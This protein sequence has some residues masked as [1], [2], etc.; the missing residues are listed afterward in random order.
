[1]QLPVSDWVHLACDLKVR[2]LNFLVDFNIQLRLKTSALLEHLQR[3][4]LQSSARMIYFIFLLWPYR[5]SCF[6]SSLTFLFW[7][8]LSF[9]VMN[10]SVLGFW[11]TFLILWSGQLP[12][13]N[14]IFQKYTCCLLSYSCSCLCLLWPHVIVVHIWDGTEININIQPPILCWDSSILLS[15]YRNIKM[16]LRACLVRFSKNSICRI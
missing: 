3:I 16:S 14:F 15:S 11:F 12:L 6:L 4:C 13:M 10:H 8:S 7:F 2:P 9:Y 1:M 5:E